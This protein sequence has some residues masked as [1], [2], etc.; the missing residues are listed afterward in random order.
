M[1][2]IS[3]FITAVLALAVITTV[4]CKSDSSEKL[5]DAEIEVAEANKNL[6]L[7]QEEYQKELKKYKIEA[8][9][10]ISKNEQSIKEFKVRIE[11]NKKEAK[12]D[13]DKKIIALEQKNSD[14]KRDLDL[15]K[16]ESKEQW[17]AFKVEFNQD[18]NEIG[19]ALKNL[20]IDSKK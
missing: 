16:L 4:S 3:S 18:M 12:A 11:S 19:D 20:T 1:K 14:M 8:Q 15:Y 9:E 7:A 17:D 6:T 13:Y 10:R 2:R 5:K